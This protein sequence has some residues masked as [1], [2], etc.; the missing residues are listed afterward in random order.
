MLIERM[1]SHLFVISGIHFD[2]STAFCGL[3]YVSL[4]AYKD[5]YS[6]FWQPH[7]IGIS[8]HDND[9][10]DIGVIY[11]TKLDQFTDV[12]HELINWM[13]DHE[14]GI[15]SYKLLWNP[16]E[17]FPDCGCQRSIM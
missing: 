16:L 8:L 6:D 11:R 2:D 1:E 17:F 15:S 14:Q 9:D 4:V 3:P 5:C 13:H 7:T 10:F 12:L